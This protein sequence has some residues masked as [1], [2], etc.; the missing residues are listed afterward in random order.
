MAGL[1]AHLRL[2]VAPRATRNAGDGLA[3][4]GHRQ[5]QG[6]LDVVNEVPL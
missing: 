3:A 2:V 5:A 4:G 1:E 6:Q